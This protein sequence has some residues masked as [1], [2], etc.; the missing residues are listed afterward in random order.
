MTRDQR[1]LAE[2]SSILNDK[3]KIQNNLNK[4]KK[5][6]KEKIIKYGILEYKEEK[7]ALQNHVQ[8]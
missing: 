1:R 6:I 5:W 3:V 4:L 7:Q 2:K 8:E